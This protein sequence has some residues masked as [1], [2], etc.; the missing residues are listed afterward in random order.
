MVSQDLEV[1]ARVN[2]LNKRMDMLKDL[3]QVLSQEVNTRYNF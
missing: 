1:T 3:V 2:V